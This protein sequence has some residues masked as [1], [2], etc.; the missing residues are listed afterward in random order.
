[1][2]VAAVAYEARDRDGLGCLRG[3][4]EQGDAVRRLAL[5]QPPHVRTAGE[6]PPR[7]RCVQ[8]GHRPQQGR[9]AAAVGADHG[10]HLSGADR[11]V[12]L[13]DHRAAGVIRR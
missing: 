13:V 3:L 5:A 4:G 7:I 2:R 9:L 6:H 10:H 8:P 12:D 11:E 1:M